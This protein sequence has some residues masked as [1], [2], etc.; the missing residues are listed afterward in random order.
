MRHTYHTE[1]WLPYPVDLVF[2]FFANPENL[3]RLMPSW[4]K[5]RIEEA[6]FSPPPPRPTSSQPGRSIAA[7]PGTHIILSFRP[8]PYLPLRIPWEAEIDEFVWN[9]HFADRQVRGPFAYWHHR[10]IVQQE[11]RA[12]TT[13]T[14]LRD[15]VEYEPPLGS[16]GEVANALFISR[17]LRRTFAYRKLRTNVLL[18]KVFPS[19]LQK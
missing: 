7:G 17:Q 4:Q 3:P 14:H 16:L 9:S 10:H 2:A 5:A 1:Q 13:G 6:I 8:I 12:N 11:S 15:E 19:P 18:D